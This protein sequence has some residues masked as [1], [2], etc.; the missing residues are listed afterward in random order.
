MVLCYLLFSYNVFSGWWYSGVGTLLI[1]FFAFLLWHQDF[2]FR[3]GLKMNRA[4][5][6]TAL[7]LM[8]IL[9]AGGYGLMKSI[10]NRN[11]ILIQYADYR[12]F[13]HDLFY[14][15]NEEI[16]LGAVLLG[17][18]RERFKK[19]HPVAVSILVA[20]LFAVVH[21]IFYRWIFTDKGILT[22]LTLV[23]LAMVGILRNNLI[24]TTGHVG[25]SW[26]FHASWMAI[27]FGTHHYYINDL[28]ALPEF[29]RFNLYLGSPITSII[30]T[31]LAILSFSLFWY[32]FK[33][34]KLIAKP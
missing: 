10:A 12:N 2:L 3:I 34:T 13:L 19:L 23:S 15:L 24:L 29:V 9:T 22:L 31:A 8:L 26:A 1:V 32:K 5:L 25:F 11:D 6:L 18:V 30:I 16:M 21:Y 14:T 33:H 17:Q 28:A 4:I 27:M 7:F 20:L